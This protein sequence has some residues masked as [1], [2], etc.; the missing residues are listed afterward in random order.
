M[1]VK[2]SPMSSLVYICKQCI[3]KRKSPERICIAGTN[4]KCICWVCK[5]TIEPGGHYVLE[6]VTY[7][8]DGEE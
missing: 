5:K 4:V 7:T 6:S 8:Q 3:E 1:N 2:S